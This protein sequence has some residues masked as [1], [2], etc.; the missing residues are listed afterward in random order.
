[1]KSCILY[2]CISIIMDNIVSYLICKHYIYQYS[3]LHN[4]TYYSCSAEIMDCELI[5]VMLGSQMCRFFGGS[6]ILCWSVSV[7]S[8]IGSF[9]SIEMLCSTAHAIIMAHT[10]SGAISRHVDN[11]IYAS[12]SNVYSIR[13]WGF[14]VHNYSFL[15]QLKQVVNMLSTDTSSTYT[16]Y[17]LR[18]V[19]RLRSYSPHTFLLV[20]VSKSLN[21]ALI[22]EISLLYRRTFH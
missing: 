10:L 9:Q 3:I 17:P 13:T 14:C 1:M 11:E 12:I 2:S 6:P 8:N 18:Y 22:Q 4:Y 15:G 21:H 16:Q 19:H 7:S 20:R 5:S